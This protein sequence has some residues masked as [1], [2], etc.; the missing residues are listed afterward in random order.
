MAQTH[1]DDAFGGALEDRDLLDGEDQHVAFARGE[2]RVFIAAG[3]FGT[4]HLVVIGRA[5][6]QA[7]VFGR[8]LRVGIDS[9]PDRHPV[10]GDRYEVR[11]GF[12]LAHLAVAFEEVGFEFAVGHGFGQHPFV[13]RN[14]PDDAFFVGEA[15]ELLHGR[16][17]ARGA[18]QFV[19]ADGVGAAEVG[20]EC[21]RVARAP[22]QDPADLI[23]L[24]DA[25][26]VH[27]G[28]R[29]L[30]LDPAVACH[31]DVG[32]FID[33]KIFFRIF[34]LRH[35]RP[36]DVAAAFGGVLLLDRLEFIPHHHPPRRFVFEQLSDLGGALFLGLQF[37]PDRH[38]LQLRELEEFGLQDG[39]G[40]NVIE[41]ETVAQTLARIGLV[42]RRTNDLDGLVDGIKDFLEAF[43]D[44]DPLLQLRQLVLQP[45]RDDIEAEVQK[46]MQDRRQINLLRRRHLRV[47][48]RDEAGQVDVEAGLQGRMLEQIGHRGLGAGAA[49]EFEHHTHHVGRFVADVGKLRHPVS[50]DV[51]GDFLDQIAFGNGVRN[52]RDEDARFALLLVLAAQV[53]RP[54]PVLINVEEFVLGVENAPACRKIRPF[55][56]LAHQRLN[57]DSSTFI[58]TGRGRST[59]FGADTCGLSVGTRQVRLTWKR[60]CKGVCLNR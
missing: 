52:R 37:L 53:D 17:V 32:V 28:V 12:V 30:A 18:R 5:H 11:D 36:G 50:G 29:P 57:T 26:V 35:I 44:V 4:D 9:Q 3:H 55:D 2:A 25:D 41:A 56:E 34:V 19:H 59:F 46:M 42:L 49:F 51:F 22:R 54:L 38:N 14:H 45:A 16:A 39:V 43:E 15:E 21:H 60:V 10:T 20:Q 27:L 6:E 1:G 58:R 40:L 33:D 31:D 47:I 8:G 24:A 23:A 7:A 48:G 13:E